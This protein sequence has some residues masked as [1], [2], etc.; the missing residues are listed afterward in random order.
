MGIATNVTDAYTF[1]MKGI[2]TYTPYEGPNSA[3]QIDWKL[4]VFYR[5]LVEVT[6]LNI[7][8]FIILRQTRVR[9]LDKYSIL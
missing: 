2:S 5:K 6:P 1:D 3:N 8:I 7:V 4:G 9:Y